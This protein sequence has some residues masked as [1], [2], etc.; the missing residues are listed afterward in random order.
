MNSYTLA[1]REL[2]LDDAWDV[3]VVGGGPAGCAAAAAAAREGAR[4]L[5]L[6]ATGC[7][8]GMGTAGLVPYWMTWGDGK[9]PVIR[10]LAERVYTACLN[11]M[12]HASKQEHSGPIDAELLKR[13]Y[14][15]LVTEAGARVLFNTQLA[16]VDAQN[17]QVD[18][19][20][21]AN[22]AGMTA[23]RAKTYVDCTGDADLAAWAGAPF[24]QG[25]PAT[26]EL[27]PVTH[28]F[29]LTNVD[30]YAYTYGRRLWPDVITAIVNSGKYPEIASRHSCN[31]PVGPGT[32]GFNAGHQWDVDNTRPE[33]ASAALI[34][35]RKIAKA[36]RDALAEYLPAAFANAF[37]VNTASLLGIREGRR[38]IGDYCLTTEDYFARRSFND[39]ICRNHYPID[40]HTAKHEVAADKQGQ[41]SVMDRY[42]HFRPGESHGI[43]YRCLCPRGLRNVLVAGRSV[44]CERPVQAAIRIMPVCLGMGEA[45][46]LA[47]ALAARETTD[48][49]S[50]DTAHLR[51]RLREEGAYLPE[52][53]PALEG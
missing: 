25:D 28:C 48:V 43:P 35:G 40:I 18:V 29:V 21:A 37:L 50:V 14:D 38:I 22:K 33:T 6:E 5:L 23:Y 49:H 10:G 31:D 45:A 4:T 2:P 1:P 47:A 30:D 11:G 46:G 27:M 3:I 7:L 20:I 52:A 26:G 9:K 36:Y 16:A 41:F 24:V 13:I 17:G 8:G 12:P 15:D 51:L 39:E 42:E 34:Q 44:S 19:I 32:I 53:M